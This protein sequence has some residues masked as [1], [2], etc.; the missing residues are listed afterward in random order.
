MSETLHDTIKTK[1]KDIDNRISNWEADI[2]LDGKNLQSAVVEQPSLLAYYDQIAVESEYLMDL[3]EMQ[4]KKIRAERTKF[5][6]D[7]FSKDYTDSAIQK[8]VEGDEAYI[9][10]YKVFLLTK[11]MYERCKSLVE[12]FKQRSYSL[13]NIVKIREHELEN[14]TIRM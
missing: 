5:I 11:E 9:K 12:A 4:V 7:N 6:R 8:V 2:S 3:M 14:I 1:L 10:T 13:N